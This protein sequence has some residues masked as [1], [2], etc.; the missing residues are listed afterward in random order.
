MAKNSEQIYRIHRF[1]S[2]LS[3]KP[4]YYSRIKP[5]LGIF[6]P[7]WIL[8]LVLGPLDCIRSSHHFDSCWWFRNPKQPPFGSIFN[9]IN[10]WRIYQPQLVNAGFQPSTVAV[11][12]KKK[13]VKNPFTISVWRNHQWGRSHHWWMDL[14]LPNERSFFVHSRSACVMAKL[15]GCGNGGLVEMVAFWSCLIINMGVLNHIL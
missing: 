1:A 2:Y 15:L 12:K 6:S 10:N 13:D 4:S 5:S 3:I 7:R 11:P 14:N 9:P 8:S